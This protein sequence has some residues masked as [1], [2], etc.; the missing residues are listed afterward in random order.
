MLRCTVQT[1]C[2]LASKRGLVVLSEHCRFDSYV[3]ELGK[4]GSAEMRATGTK[5]HSLCVNGR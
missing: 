1:P 4:L 2:C 3:P 5:L